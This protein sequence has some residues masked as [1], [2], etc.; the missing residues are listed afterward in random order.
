MYASV[1][2]KTHAWSLYAWVRICSEREREGEEKRY[3]S[4]VG[5]SIESH[6]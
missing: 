6:Q 4:F 3:E 1:S 5:A 2:M